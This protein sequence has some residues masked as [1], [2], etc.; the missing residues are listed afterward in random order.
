[1]DHCLK[2]PEVIRFICDGLNSESAY[3]MAL[4]AR[5]FVEPALD[6]RWEIVPS[7]MSI[8]S[9]LPHDLWAVTT[10]EPSV[11]VAVRVYRSRLTR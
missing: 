7:L 2:I 6:V 11:K 9:C 4:V 5:R 1:M 3:S 10:W 8:V